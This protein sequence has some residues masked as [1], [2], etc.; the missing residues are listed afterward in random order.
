VGRVN[1]TFKRLR[2]EKEAGLIT[3][4]AATGL[5]P[6]AARQIV[7][8]MA[9]QGADLVMLEA[10][11]TEEINAC[12]GSAAEARLANEVPLVLLCDY[13]A[14]GGH[15]MDA[16][17]QACAASGLDGIIVR[18][19]GLEEQARLKVACEEVDIIAAAYVTSA[20][21]VQET[22]ERLQNASGF[23]L[24]DPES[25]KARDLVSLVREVTTLP[26]ALMAAE[27]TAE[28]VAQAAEIA[29]AVV[30]G[31]MLGE[32]LSALPEDEIILEAGEFAREM[33]AATLRTGNEC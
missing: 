5:P 15:S 17:A 24:C 29:H 19:L 33:K 25:G 7:P 26:V 21:G 14:L 6:E 8:V 2:W 1:V 31:A 11:T 4:A 16:I 28:S 18:D 3:R 27:D 23:V 30:V 13:R 20:I 32:R 10:G 22:R 9:R 12:F